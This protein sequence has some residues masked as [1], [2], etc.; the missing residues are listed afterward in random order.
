VQER[1]RLRN[2]FSACGCGIFA[3]VAE[4]LPLPID[5]R[6]RTIER[7]DRHHASSPKGPA[8]LSAKPSEY[9]KFRLKWEAGAQTTGLESTPKAP[10]NTELWAVPELRKVASGAAK[11]YRYAFL[12]MPPRHP[13][14]A[15]RSTRWPTF[16]W[17]C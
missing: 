3:T 1:S 12:D 16:G 14:R 10:L 2:G 15:R 7:T 13:A 17:R 11:S 9:K 5:G 4:R 6:Q 8:A